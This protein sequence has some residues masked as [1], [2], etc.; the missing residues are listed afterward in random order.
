MSGFSAFVCE[1]VAYVRISCEWIVGGR[2][3]C[4]SVWVHLCACSPARVFGAYDH[5]AAKKM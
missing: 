2:I 3:Y 4:L 5:K 1:A